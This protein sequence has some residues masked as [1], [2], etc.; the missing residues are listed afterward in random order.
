MPIL[1]RSTI[2]VALL[3]A[4]TSACVPPPAAPSGEPAPGC[5]RHAT[6]G[7]DVSYSGEPSEYDNLSFWTSRDG[8]CSGSVAGSGTL[9][10]APTAPDAAFLCEV[11]LRQHLDGRIDSAL[12]PW[13]APFGAMG[14][15]CT[16]NVAS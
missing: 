13:S 11:L 14:Y 5:R 16:T 10:V 6:G 3:C 4:A 9:I 7:A 12:G 2:V 15:V 8:S 1:R